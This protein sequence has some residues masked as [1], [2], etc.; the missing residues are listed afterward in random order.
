MLLVL[1]MMTQATVMLTMSTSSPLTCVAGCTTLTV[2]Y[3]ATSATLAAAD[4][5]YLAVASPHRPSHP[6]GLMTT[7]LFPAQLDGLRP[8]TTYTISLYSHPANLPSIAWG[9]SWKQNASAINCTTTTVPTAGAAAVADHTVATTPATTVGASTAVTAHTDATAASSGSR[10]LRVFRISEYAFTPDFLSNH[11][12]ATANALPLYLM[13][14]DAS[15]ICEQPWYLTDITNRWST[16]QTAL[17]AACPHE[18]GTAFQCMRCMDTNRQQVEQ[19]CGP[20]SDEN[21]LK[22]EGSFGVHWYCGIGWPSSV[23]DEG[24]ITEY[25]VERLPV[26]PPVQDRGG[27]EDGFSGYLSCNGPEVDAFGKEPRNPYCVCMCFNDRL[28]AHQP[29]SQLKQDCFVDTLP[30]AN[31]TQ[32]V[33]MLPPPPHT[34]G[35]S[36]SLACLAL[37]LH[38]PAP[39][40][41]VSPSPPACP[42]LLHPHPPPPTRRCPLPQPQCP[43][44]PLPPPP[45]HAPPVLRILMHAHFPSL[46]SHPRRLFPHR[47][48]RVPLRSCR[49]PTTP[50]CTTSVV[51]PCTCRTWVSS[52]CPRSTM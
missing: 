34:S 33:S 2:H 21:T 40:R 47:T 41:P 20:F 29:L 42:P 45:P 39:P 30:W 19:S 23:A 48:A 37:P 44:L 13:T 35:P 38:V 32:C 43:L 26:P 36:V 14:C 27:G 25:C 12:A 11:N 51:R 5:H 10:F 31:E 17:A 49:P 4:L 9:P 6:L 52:W 22:G 16:C 1:I 15:G 50:H 28:L 46:A 3:A 24:P 18:R 8:N 7:S